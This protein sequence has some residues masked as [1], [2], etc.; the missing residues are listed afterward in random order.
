MAR[1][2]AKPNRPQA[3]VWH[4]RDL[5]IDDNAALQNCVD[6]GF[7][8]VG[9]FVFDSH[10]LQGL[11]AL[12]RRVDFV[13]GAVEQL[14]GAYAKLGLAFI[15]V[16]GD[17]GNL[18]PS[19]ARLHQA[20]AVFANR[21]Y[22]PYAHRRDAGVRAALNKDGV[23][24]SLSKDHVIFESSEILTLAKTRF[25]VFTP[26]KNAWLKR[27]SEEAPRLSPSR[28]S[29]ERL[30]LPPR[31]PSPIPALEDMGF[32]RTD[33]R[34]LG[35]LIGEKGGRSTVRKFADRIGQYA[36]LRDFPHSDS[37]SR[38]GPHL[39]FGTVSIRRLALWAHATGGD[40]ANTWLSELVWRDFHS[41][42]LDLCPRLAQGESYQKNYDALAWANDPAK[43]DAWRTGR[44]GY[45]FVDAGMRE[46]LAT[47]HMHNRA[48]MVAA[49]FLAKHLDC[50]WRL[51]EAHFA[52]H[53][54]D[55]DLASNNG[56]WQWSAS[57]GCDAQPYFRIFNPHAQSERFDPAGAYI[58]KWVPELALCPAKQ[59]H[60]PSLAKPETLAE[61]N[62]VLG[63]TYP[64]PIVSHPQARLAA[65]AKYAAA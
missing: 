61:A 22:E 47:G 57:T 24:L 15:C 42:I 50:D 28:A 4:R 3:F 48:R 12:D 36:A 29:L 39:R 2:D 27:F 63:S 33:L 5:R 30:R 31:Q 11:D 14:G 19:L 55:Y 45:P 7:E 25:A 56:G 60:Q 32:A 17:P 38:L 8:P 65:L 20:R 1:V 62:V 54:L 9:L 43:L 13:H 18:V 51:G 26:Y 23:G 49:S 37:T 6:A 16:F 52:R 59:I 58:K 64:L 21:D 10:I 40:G 46:L 41:A 34:S 53:L 44:T 35:V